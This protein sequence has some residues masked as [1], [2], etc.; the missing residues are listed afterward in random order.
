MNANSRRGHSL[1]SATAQNPRVFFALVF[2]CAQRG[3]DRADLAL[4]A[5]ACTIASE[6]I[7]WIGYFDILI[8]DEAA[9]L[10]IAIL[11]VSVFAVT[12]RLYRQD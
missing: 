8:S 4:S 3:T 11:G 1:P 5:P 2:A 7:S 10:F 12:W 9:A 6:M